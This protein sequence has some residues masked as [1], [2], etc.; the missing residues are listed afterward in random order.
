MIGS[1]PASISIRPYRLE[2]AEALAEA[3]RESSR[4]ILPWMAWCRPDFSAADA[5]AW[6]GPQVE[7][8]AARRAFEFAIV[9]SDGRYLGGCAL[10]QIHVDDRF[11]NLGYWVRTSATGQGVATA[12]VGRLVE[13]ARAETGLVRLELVIVVGNRASARVAEKAGA[14]LEGTLA[15]RIHLHGAPR[16][17]WMYSIVSPR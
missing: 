5:A 4:E 14:R 7:A 1:E 10:N 8:F 3:A 17:A 12:A 6:L 2:D 15:A 9:G 11:A 16:D 13:F